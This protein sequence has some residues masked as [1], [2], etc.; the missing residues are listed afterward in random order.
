MLPANGRPATDGRLSRAV[1]GKRPEHRLMPILSATEPY[2]G[3]AASIRL[4][5]V[6]LGVELD[7]LAFV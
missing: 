1:L 5:G 6:G 4:L 7:R 2:V 3:R